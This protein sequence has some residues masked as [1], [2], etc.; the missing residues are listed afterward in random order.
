MMRRSAGE[1]FAEITLFV[2]VM[3]GLLI[4]NSFLLMFIFWELV[5]VCSYLLIGFWYEKPSA[6]SAAKKAF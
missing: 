4:A 2:A 1:V 3:L 5:G 6:A